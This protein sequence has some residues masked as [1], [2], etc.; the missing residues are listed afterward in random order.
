MTVAVL[1]TDR[2][3]DFAN[4]GKYAVMVFHPAIL[5]PERR[6]FPSLARAKAACDCINELARAAA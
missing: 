5:Q 4:P 3:N 6:L 1:M 2:Y